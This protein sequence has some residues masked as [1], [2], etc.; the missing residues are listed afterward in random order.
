[1][2]DVS[3]EK[4]IAETCGSPMKF[5]NSLIDVCLL[6]KEEQAKEQEDNFENPSPTKG[7]H[8]DDNDLYCASVNTMAPHRASY[9]EGMLGKRGISA[10]KLTHQNSFDSQSGSFRA[11]RVPATFR[12]MSAV[13]EASSAVSDAQHQRW[14]E[15]AQQP[16]SSEPLSTGMALAS[17]FQ[18][19][20][21]NPRGGLRA[22]AFVDNHSPEKR[23][24]P[25]TRGST[26]S[27]CI[28]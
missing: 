17:P 7:Y 9:V 14:K 20:P 12:D 22:S 27:A 23:L 1:M 4:P 10:T 11:G 25:E 19:A 2:S 18:R 16:A 24:R 21:L 6:I 3:R 28:T 8:G 26:V 15:W 13:F 5:L